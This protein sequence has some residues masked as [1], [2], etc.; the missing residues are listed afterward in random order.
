MQQGNRL[1]SPLSNLYLCFGFIFPHPIQQ[2]TP[3]CALLST[4]QDSTPP[5]PQRFHFW[6]MHILENVSFSAQAGQQGVGSEQRSEQQPLCYWLQPDRSERF[7]LCFW[8]PGFPL[9]NQLTNYHV[10]TWS[11]DKAALA[12]STSGAL[13]VSAKTPTIS[14]RNGTGDH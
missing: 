10:G 12:S 11:N 7:L 6:K 8:N 4:T 3:F 14:S 2:G 5:P 9:R 1:P 13:R